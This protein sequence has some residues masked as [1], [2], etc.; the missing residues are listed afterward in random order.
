MIISAY[1]GILGLPDMVISFV[2]Q[3]SQPMV[4]ESLREW[5]MLEMAGIQLTRPFLRDF[6]RAL[7]LA[8]QPQIIAREYFG[9]TVDNNA[10]AAAVWQ[11]LTSTF[12]VAGSVGKLVAD[13]ID[14]K[15]STRLPTASYTTPPTAAQNAAAVRDVA[16]RARLVVRWVRISRAEL[17]VIRGARSF[18]GR[19]Q[20]TL[21]GH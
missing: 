13:D 8:G 15:I 18:P 7:E 6:K 1:L 14:A 2:I 5:S 4:P 9:V 3:T 11:V 19:M 10:I 17:L 16:M 20:Q 12:T 21:P